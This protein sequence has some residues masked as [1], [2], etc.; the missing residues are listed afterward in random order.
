METGDFDGAMRAWQ[1]SVKVNPGYTQGLTFLGLAHM[2][3]RAYDSAVTWTDSART[4]DPRYFFAWMT[5]GEVETERGNF[6]RAS[7]AYAA[8]PTFDR[9]RATDAS[10][11]CLSRS[12]L[13]RRGDVGRASML[14][15]IPSERSL[16]C[17]SERAQ[18]Q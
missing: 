10:S 6:A 5:L 18:L 2:W 14:V 12:G 9:S 13:R 8:I 17:H 1:R 4:L 16:P 15:V 3:R 11:Q 7:A